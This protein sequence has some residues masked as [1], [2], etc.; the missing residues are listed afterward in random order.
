MP[1]KVQRSEIGSQKDAEVEPEEADVH[2]MRPGPPRPVGT[3][4][5]MELVSFN[6]VI[7]K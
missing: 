3:F 7:N 6:L 5:Q 2:A 1:V 4:R